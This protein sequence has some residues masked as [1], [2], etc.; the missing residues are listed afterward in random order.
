MTTGVELVFLEE[1][2]QELGLFSVE[3]AQRNLIN[4][5]KYL[6][7]GNE[8]E[9]SLIGQEATVAN[10]NMRKYNIPSKHKK[11]LFY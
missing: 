10:E 9:G 4:V 2:L 11:K 6:I 8:K 1:R 5:Y 7:E 3:K